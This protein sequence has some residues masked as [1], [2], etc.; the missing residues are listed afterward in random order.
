MVVLD[1]GTHRPAVKSVLEKLKV[2]DDWYTDV[3]RNKTEQ[4]Y[5]SYMDSFLPEAVPKVLYSH[6]THH[7]FCMEILGDDLQNRKSRLQQVQYHKEH[8]RETATIPGTVHARSF[9]STS[10]KE[11]FDTLVNF[12]QLWIEPY[13]LQT[14]R[15]HP[16]LT[17]YFEVGAHRIAQ[18]TMITVPKI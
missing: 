4:H 14:A 15:R 7:F 18:Y 6:D 16:H 11:Q 13:L 8:A 12:R 17:A 3:N 9:G 1:D 10:L 5:L 2:K